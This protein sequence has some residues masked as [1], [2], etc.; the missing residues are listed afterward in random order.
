MRL[1]TYSEQAGVTKVG[2]IHGPE[3]V[4]LRAAFESILCEEERLPVHKA[5][6][7]ARRA[8][9]CSM[10]D[11]IRCGQDGVACVRRVA[12]LLDRMN[13][14]ELGNTRSPSGDRIAYGKDKV[15]LLKPLQV[16]RALNIGANYNA[17]LAMMRIV[18]PFQ[19][20]AETF[21]KLPQA[22]IGPEEGIVWPVSSE[23][24]TCEMELGVIIGTKGKRIPKEDALDYVFGY[25]VVNDVTAIDLITRGLGEGREGLPGFYYLALAKSL[26]TFESIGPCITLKEEIPD[27]QNLDGELKVNGVLRVRGSTSDMR[28]GVAE[29]IEYLSQDIT[30]Y[31][32]DLIATGAMATEEYSPQVRVQIGDQVE[33]E[34][35]KIGVLRNHIVG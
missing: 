16:F 18:E 7:A 22:V 21:W 17:Y 25:T 6:D 15:S 32:G 23:Q 14:V 20:T 2:L 35:A 9:P 31:P 27:P 19:G 30:L 26:D 34:I 29:L 10:M 11:L 28:L 8:I 1:V 24:I 5:R 13:D 33:M 3:V 4:D 12:G